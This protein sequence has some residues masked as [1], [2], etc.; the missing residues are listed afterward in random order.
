ME[1][2]H[3]VIITSRLEPGVKVG[4]AFVSIAYAKRPGE[5]GRTRFRYHID[6]GK[7]SYTGDDLQSGMGSASLQ[8]GLE[9]LLAYLGAAGESYAYRLRRGGK[10]KGENEDLFEPKVVEWAYQH[11]DEISMLQMELEE[12]P[13][14][15]RE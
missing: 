5:R 1:L 8:G 11:S 3:P 2:H 4:K 6:I 7:K 9:S 13:N 15:I 10:E 14:L 12:T